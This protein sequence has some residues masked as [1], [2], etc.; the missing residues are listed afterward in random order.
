MLLGQPRTELGVTRT[1]V[2]VLEVFLQRGE[3]G[4][5]DAAAV[6]RPRHLVAE[7]LVQAT[8]SL[9]IEPGRH[10]MAVHAQ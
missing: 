7:H 9:G 8:R 2:D 1:A 3:G 4:G 5:R 6:R 10:T